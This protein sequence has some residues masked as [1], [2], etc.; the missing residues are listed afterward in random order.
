MRIAKTKIDDLLELNSNWLSRH[1]LL[2]PGKHSITWSNSHYRA[3]ANI[4]ARQDF[5]ELSYRTKL[6]KMVQEVEIDWA[7]CGAGGRRAY[8]LCP[9]C[10]KRCYKLFLR[11]FRWVCHRCTG[12]LYEVQIED[13]AD[14]ALRR[15]KKLRQRLGAPMM[16]GAPVEKPKGMHWQT[17][18]RLWGRLI[19]EEEKAFG[20]LVE[21]FG[22]T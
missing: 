11:E 15:S 22:I 5:I 18:F 2:E 14:K 13:D 20:F 4:L 12:L 8:F 10:G 19:H 9:R 16:T 17:Y 1:G 3:S 6:G 7:K 21:R